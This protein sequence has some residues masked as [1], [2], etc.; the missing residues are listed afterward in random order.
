MTQCWSQ[1]T[2]TTRS[3]VCWE[4]IPTSC[5]SKPVYLSQE[6]EGDPGEDDVSEVLYNTKRSVDH[7]V[8]QPLCVVVF[9]YR[10]NGLAAGGKRI[11]ITRCL[12]I[13]E[14]F[15]SFCLWSIL[16]TERGGG[17]R[18]WVGLCGMCTSSNWGQVGRRTL[19]RVARNITTNS[20][21]W[22]SSRDKYQTLRSVPTD[23]WS[24]KATS[25]LPPLLV[26]TLS[27]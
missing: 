6:V 3:N 9:F 22:L 5:L 27:W 10:V 18:W 7:P 23:T 19:E 12:E 4:N 17:A 26:T 1:S 21:R 8:G 20:H 2:N 24:C 16:V 25:L 15:L 13:V 11:G 14:Q